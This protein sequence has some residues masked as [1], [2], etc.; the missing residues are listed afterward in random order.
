MHIFNAFDHA[1]FLE[2]SQDLLHVA[3]NT[4]IIAHVCDSQVDIVLWLHLI[5]IMNGEDFR[6]K[7]REF[8]LRKKEMGQSKSE[9]RVT[10]EEEK[11]MT[12]ACSVRL[13]LEDHTVGMWSKI[14][15]RE[16]CEDGITEVEGHNICRI[17]VDSSIAT[18]NWDK[19]IDKWQYSTICGIA[20]DIVTIEWGI[21]II[22]GWMV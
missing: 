9:T 15:Y 20:I 7:I 17:S 18:H 19:V 22:G 1:L 21:Q 4:W 12:N 2:G 13:Y 16:C 10:M 14:H 3:F 8:K 11:K 5:K 6:S